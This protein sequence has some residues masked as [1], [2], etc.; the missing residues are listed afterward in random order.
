MRIVLFDTVIQGVHL[1]LD[2]YVLFNLLLNPAAFVL[3]GAWFLR[4]HGAT[5]RRALLAPFMLMCAVLSGSRLV[6]F[7]L[8]YDHYRV[9][10][11]NPLIPSAG[12]YTMYGGFVVGLCMIGLFARIAR[13]DVWRFLDCMAPGWAFG[14]LINKVGCFLNGCC[15]GVPTDS[16]L[17]VRFPLLTYPDPVHPVQLYEAFVG[18]VGCLIVIFLLKKLWGSG[19]PFFGFATLYAISRF[20]FHFLRETPIRM[21]A[22]PWF[23]IIGYALAIL[24]AGGILLSRIAASRHQASSGDGPA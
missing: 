3:I 14:I 19:I 18:A 13:M 22:S 20:V 2:S 15:M 12:G 6:W 17:G 21:S 9:N 7:L 1:H 16:I 24:V 5:R 11:I 4:R 10:G 8:A 23:G